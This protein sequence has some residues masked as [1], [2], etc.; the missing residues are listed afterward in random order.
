MAADSCLSPADRAALEILEH[1][2][3]LLCPLT[4]DVT[5]RET[6]MISRRERFGPKLA[7]STGNAMQ[8]RGPID[9]FACP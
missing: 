9:G 2:V 3:T 8:V 5:G 7:E 4:V 1:W 6:D